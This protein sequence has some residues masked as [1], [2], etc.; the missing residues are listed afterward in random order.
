MGFTVWGEGRNRFIGEK[1]VNF[2]WNTNYR[3]GSYLQVVRIDLRPEKS[4]L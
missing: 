1:S 2:I 3:G 4:T